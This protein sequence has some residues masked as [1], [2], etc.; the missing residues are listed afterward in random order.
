MNE[1]KKTRTRVRVAKV[2]DSPPA[3]MHPKYRLGELLRQK[4]GEFGVKDGATQ[5]AD[6]CGL[7]KRYTVSEWM[8]IPAGSE[9]EINHL[10]LFKVLEF[11]DLQNSEQLLTIH[12]KKMLKAIA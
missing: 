1:A 9:K 2:P 8:A 5:L 11:F 3:I 10:V 12:H 7:K 6:F 4:F